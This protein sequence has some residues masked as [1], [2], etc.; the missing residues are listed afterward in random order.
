MIRGTRSEATEGVGKT[1]NVR[2]NALALKGTPSFKKRE[3]LKAKSCP[4][5]LQGGQ[6][7][8]LRREIKA[9]AN[10]IYDTYVF[11]PS[12]LRAPP[13]EKGRS[14]KLL[15]NRTHTMPVGAGA[16]IDTAGVTI[17]TDVVRFLKQRHPRYIFT[18]RRTPI[19]AKVGYGEKRQP[20]ARTGSGKKDA[21][22]ILFTCYFITFLA[23]LCCP[24]PGAVIYKFPPFGFCGHAPTIVP[25]CSGC[26]VF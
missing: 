9:R 12:A 13:L 20:V 17:K 21:V 7:Q 4:L 26:V 23:T 3:S 22:T 16:P 11:I 10:C 14:Y 5:C 24:F 25:V 15:C 2:T 6:Q 8:M 18:R 1:T 19:V